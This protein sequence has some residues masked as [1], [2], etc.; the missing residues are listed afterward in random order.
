MATI[1]AVL[2]KE[3]RDV[4]TFVSPEAAVMRLSVPPAS[5]D[6]ACD[7]ITA[8]GGEAFLD[9]GGGL[10]WCAV[11]AIARATATGHQGH[12]DGPRRSRDADTGGRGTQGRGARLSSPAGRTA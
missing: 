3:V 1:P 5:G 9:W 7:R 12:C 11:H 6:V 4:A 2:W 10:V 8:S